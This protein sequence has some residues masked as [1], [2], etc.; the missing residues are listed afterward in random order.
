MVAHSLNWRL[1]DIVGRLQTAPALY[2][3]MLIGVVMPLVSAWVYPTY[4][5]FVPSPMMEW[6]RL[7]ELP[8][9]ISEMLVVIWAMARGMELRQF[10]E[11]LPRDC[12]MALGLLFAGLWIS[13][14]LVSKVPMTSLTISLSFVV[15]LL[16]GCSVYHLW[17]QC[18]GGAS[19]E[20]FLGGLAVGLIPLALVTAYRFLLPPVLADVPGGMIEWASSLPGF[21]SVRHFGSWTGAIAAIFAAAILCRRDEAAFT[22]YDLA[23]FLSI[24]MTIWSGTRAA[25]LAI[26]LSCAILV[27]STWRFPSL[28]VIGRLLMLTGLAASLAYVLIPYSDP[29]FYL[30][31]PTDQYVSSNRIS[32]GRMELWDA[33]YRKWLQAPWFG[34][35]SGSTF[36]EVRALG[37]KHTQPHNFVLQFLVSWGVVGAVGGF[38]LLG[39]AVVSAHRGALRNP[40]AWP[41]MAGLYALLAMASLEGMLH[42]PRFVMLIMA[43]LAI[44]FRLTSREAAPD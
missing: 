1:P 11:K 29:A 5:H 12:A 4:R 10:T 14:L 36:W 31:A 26:G 15:H 27:I 43:L 22:W 3:G 41:L 20:H 8:F 44:I 42:Y 33:T 28:R 17:R 30:F 9:V 38:W 32:S 35:G 40:D 24:A 34:W 39:R 18:K 37:W 23:Y 21:I 25:I 13:T 6:T 7:Q 19:L 16:F 2:I